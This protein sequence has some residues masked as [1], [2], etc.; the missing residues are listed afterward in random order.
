MTRER[1]RLAGVDTDAGERAVELM[2]GAVQGTFGPQVIGEFGGFAAAAVLPADVREPVLVMSADGVGT[3]TALAGRLGRWSGLGQD[4]VAMCVDDVAC[5]GARPLFLLDYLATERLDPTAVAE[6]V[7]SIAAACRQA[8]CALVGGETAEHPGLL[9]AGGLD[10][11]GFCVGVVERD[12][13]LDGQAS[14]VGD[15][16]IGISASG[17]HANGYSLVR[18]LV[19]EDRLDLAE[20]YRELVERTLGAA[21]AAETP[22]GPGENQGLTLGD[23]LLE[24]TP[25][26]SPDL[27]ALR[28]ELRRMGADVH[29]LGHITGG[30]LPTNVPRALARTQAARLDP[31]RWPVPSVLRCLATLAGLTPN[32]MRATFNGGLGMVVVVEPDAA[33]PA[34]EF[35][36]RRGLTAWEVG[37]VTEAD[38]E[39][40]YHEAAV[41]LGGR[42]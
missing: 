33:T 14:R 37:E 39:L 36:A 2:R 6:V 28:A 10:V 20:P 31:S 22:L 12:G 25:I 16:I 30:G 32:E 29:G 41:G 21:A 7:A 3:K 9:A 5:L 40:R 17:L 42:R 11:A 8:G 35:L 18:A 15:R 1:Y 13:L 26:Y 19:R 38:G 23:V 34:I 4:L 24:P 27:L